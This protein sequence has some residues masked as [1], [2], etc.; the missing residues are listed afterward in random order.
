[1]DSLP[2]VVILLIAAAIVP[3]LPAIVRHWGRCSPPCW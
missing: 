1:M 3:L 2:P